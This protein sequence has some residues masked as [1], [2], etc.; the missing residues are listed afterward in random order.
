MTALRSEMAIHSPLPAGVAVECRDRDGNV[1]R[2]T[3]DQIAA[4]YERLQY[5]DGQGTWRAIDI[6]TGDQLATGTYGGSR[7]YGGHLVTVDR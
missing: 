3:V 5:R 4:I 7:Q 2:I 1:Y 6:P